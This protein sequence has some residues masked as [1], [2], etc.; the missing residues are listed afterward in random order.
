M[1]STSS[2]TAKKQ[3]VNDCSDDPAK[4]GKSPI[5]VVAFTTAP[6]HF[7]FSCPE[8]TMR[9]KGTVQLHQADKKDKWT[10]LRANGLPPSEFEVKIGGDG[11]TMTIVD[12]H[13]TTGAY[14]Y[15]VT[16]RDELGC[17]H[18]SP[19]GRPITT[20]PMIRNR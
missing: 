18:T 5:V 7:D 14:Y 11:K 6:E 17:E 15:T 8:V 20:P 13:K 19:D 2:D 3:K 12:N 9:A 1:A 16:I 4:P 10:F